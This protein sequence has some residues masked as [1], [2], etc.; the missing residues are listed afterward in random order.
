ME[1]NYRRNKMFFFYFLILAKPGGKHVPA[2]ESNDS[3]P[4]VEH[5]PKPTKSAGGRKRF[6]SKTDSNNNAAEEQPATSAPART[7]RRFRS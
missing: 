7:G 2:P 4:P 3:E 1:Y 6:N 5:A